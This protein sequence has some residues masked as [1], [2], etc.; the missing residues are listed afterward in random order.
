MFLSNSRVNLSGSPDRGCNKNEYKVEN[1]FKI[2]QL[3]I[4]SETYD[5]KAL[6]SSN[7][8]PKNELSQNIQQR[9]RLPYTFNK[10][11]GSGLSAVVM[12]SH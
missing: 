12:R 3:C 2:Y 6:G 9:V 7:L 11:L 10:F 4:Y 1:V 8:D 5:Q